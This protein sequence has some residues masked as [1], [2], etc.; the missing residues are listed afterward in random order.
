RLQDLR[1][2]ID[3]KNRRGKSVTLITGFVG[4]EEDLNS[5]GRILKTKCGVGGAVKEGG[6]LIQ[7]DH[8]QRIID[9]LKDEG[10]LK[11]KGIGG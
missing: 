8:K 1:V 9:L 6:I 3:K 11:T 4:T 7:G 5:L 10:Y 2:Q